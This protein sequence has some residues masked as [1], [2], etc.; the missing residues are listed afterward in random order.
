[1]HGSVHKKGHAMSE[2]TTTFAEIL[3]ARSRGE[4]IPEGDIIMTAEEASFIDRLR[5]EGPPQWIRD[6]AT[7][8]VTT[9]RKDPS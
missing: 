8:N 9:Q 4:P 5:E 2:T 1:M 6:L 7:E 3:V